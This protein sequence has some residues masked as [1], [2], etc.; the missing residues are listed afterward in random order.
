MSNPHAEGHMPGHPEVAAKTDRVS[1]AS[2]RGGDSK[3]EPVFGRLATAMVTPFTASGELD[4]P[5]ARALARVLVEQQRNDTLVLNGTTGESPT[6]TDDE[7][8]A[9]VR[10]VREELGDR[11]RLVSGVGSNITSHS[12]ELAQRAVEDGADGVLLVT[13]YYSKPTQRGIVEHFAA[14]AGATELP[15]MVYDIPGRTAVPIHT[16][17]L[18]ELA[19]LPTVVAVKD[20]K[21]DVVGSAQVMAQTD[22]AYYSG[23]DALTLPLLSV[24]AV[25]VVGTST[26]F[27][28]AR[29]KDLLDAWVAGDAA[30]ALA[31]HR[32]LLPSYLAVFAEPGC[33]MVKST[34]AALGRGT[35]V[36][37]L[38]MVPAA[39]QLVEAFIATL[40]AADLL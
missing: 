6:T 8:S 38:P 11:V 37:R 3:R 17:T 32:Q 21:A 1:D 9:L 36:Q 27:T 5:G 4:L 2:S 22:L 35:G 13:P 19:Q 25:G 15:L 20:A 40:T 23:D 18:I 30:Q 39:P 28:G 31:I 33:S 16:A 10:A 7:K 14:V 29:T 26:H 12:V 34:L 24:G